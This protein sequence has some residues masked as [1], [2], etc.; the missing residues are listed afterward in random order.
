MGR[1]G[2]NAIESKNN[3][4]NH[5]T[6]IIRKKLMRKITC[7]R[8]WSGVLLLSFIL[9]ACENKMDEHY[10]IPDWL[11]G[12]AWEV[13]E[14]RGDYS[15]FLQGIEL[16]GFKPIVEGKSILTVMAPN[17]DAFRTY[18]TSKGVSSIDQ[19]PKTEISKLIGFHLMYYS[20]SK[21]MLEN[22]RPDGV[23]NS[24]FAAGLYYKH[25]TKSQDPIEQVTI[26]EESTG[27]DGLPVSTSRNI[28]LY[29]PE[30]FLPVFSYH[31]FNSKRIDPVYNYEYFY[32]GSTWTGENG[33]NVSNAS[34]TEYGIV[35]DNGYIYT[36]DKV[37]EPLETIFT[38][39][40]NDMSTY[41]RFLAMYEQYALYE[42]N[43]ELTT[44]YGNG[45]DLYLHGHGNDLPP[46]A[47]EWP[48][49]NFRSISTLSSTAYSVF[50]P[51]N[52]A[53]DAFFESYWHP[54]G[55][56][57]FNEVDPIA[58]SYMLG[59]HVYSGLV[60]FP[61]EITRGDIITRYNTK[62]NIDVTKVKDRKMCVNGVF[63][64]LEEMAV[65][66]IYRAVTGAAFR[67]K[68]FSWYLFLLK[69]SSLLESLT[70]PDVNMIALMPTNEQLATL[71]IVRD[72]EGNLMILEDGIPVALSASAMQNI[73]NMHLVTGGS[74]LPSSGTRVI[75]TNSPFN[76]WYVKDGKITTSAIYTAGKVN[77]ANYDP[78]VNFSEE[79][80]NGEHWSNGSVYSYSGEVFMP[81]GS[82]HLSELLS[83]D[84]DATRPFYQFARLIQGSDLVSNGALNF[85]GTHFVVFIPTN[86]AIT[87]A[88]TAGRIPGVSTDGT[89]TD[90]A[91]LSDY[92]QY[93]FLSAN[94]NGIV[95]Y[96]YVGGD[97]TGTFNTSK[98][99]DRT[100]TGVI[101]ARLSIDEN[102]GKLSLR[103][104]NG[105]VVEIDERFDY[106][107]FTYSDGGFHLIK[108]VMEY[109][110]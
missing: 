71:D 37:L 101:Y 25:R 87:Q 24:L 69:N 74:A 22:Y 54:G 36:I 57:S 68:R 98:V 103:T 35:T 84:R 82:Q 7:I 92:L 51:S 100:P 40:T 32:T 15:I 72:A 52:T 53:F 60:V 2:K 6:F 23:E 94:V 48:T 8:R 59:N 67:E 9:S 1:A 75:R 88:I 3:I 16:A 91:L 34:V 13:L 81:T 5:T 102:A 17:V 50:A 95:D 42:Q 55:Y 33:F 89:I 107:P 44:N 104:N 83:I 97:C 110:N 28:T 45:S 79:L 77:N 12:S 21:S 14:S 62:I 63:Y 99:V 49:S 78:F 108:D 106:F 47:Y 43:V 76:Y 73:V 11:K 105:T 70:S 41:S 4:Y 18:L 31:L 20:Y 85:I 39:L 93:Y 30:R 80:F 109:T 56:N 96:P 38:E 46:I 26:Y 10:K 64:G 19:L 90:R 86:E 58:M 27:E 65:P 61:E 66:E 29:H